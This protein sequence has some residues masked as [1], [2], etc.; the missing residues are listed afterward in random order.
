MDRYAQRHFRSETPDRLLDRAWSDYTL[1]KAM[2]RNISFTEAKFWIARIYLR[3]ALRAA[4]RLLTLF[5]S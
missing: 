2:S 4:K 3:I 1:P 5:R